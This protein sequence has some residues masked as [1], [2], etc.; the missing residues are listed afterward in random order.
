VITQTRSRPSGPGLAAGT[1]RSAGLTAARAQRRYP[2]LQ[3]CAVL[4]LFGHGALSIDGF[5][6]RGSVYAMLV[7]AAYLGLAA[8]G[9]TIVVLLGGVDFA[10]PAYILLGETATL[11]LTGE[12]HWPA[13]TAI[14]AEQ[15]VY[16]VVILLIAGGYGRVRTDTLALLT[17]RHVGKAQ[18]LISGQRL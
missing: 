15:V 7:L 1:L 12:L 2:V 11:Q 10:I 14:A 13:G 16:G 9:Q 5:T 4:V 17:P 3:G 6:A 18:R 8:L